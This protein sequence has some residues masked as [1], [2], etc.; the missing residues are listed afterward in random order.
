[1]DDV[2]KRLGEAAGV[3]IVFVIGKEWRGEGDGRRDVNSF[4]GRSG[5]EIG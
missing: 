2:K 5:W 3:S 4:L 1:M